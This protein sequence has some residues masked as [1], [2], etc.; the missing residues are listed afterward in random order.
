[1]DNGSLYL[2]APAAVPSIIRLNGSPS[3][4]GANEIQIDASS[5]G[6]TIKLLSSSDVHVPGLVNDAD[7]MVYLR[8]QRYTANITNVSVASFT[9]A[10]NFP[11]AF[12]AGVVPNVH[13]NTNGT[14]GAFSKAIVT[15]ANISNTGFTLWARSGDG[16][17]M[18]AWAALPVQIT[19][20]V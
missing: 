9:Q 18:G 6:G 14:A 17:A 19:A 4:F 10:L 7:N 15:A 8:G 3:A 16:T 13:C 11:V 5:S 20:L 2:A 1:M 12:P